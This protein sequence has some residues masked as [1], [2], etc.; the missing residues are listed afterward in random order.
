MPHAGNDIQKMIYDRITGQVAGLNVYA[1]IRRDA[2]APYCIIGNDVFVRNDAKDVDIQDVNVQINIWTD[3]NSYVSIN[4]FIDS[5]KDALH[6]QEAALR[7]ILTNN[8]SDWY[9]IECILDQAQSYVEYGASDV[10]Q[11]TYNRGIMDFTIK[12]EDNA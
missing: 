5:I 2:V 7:T 8:G 10:G 11:E 9:L 3:S 6:R 4:N 1:G 12:I